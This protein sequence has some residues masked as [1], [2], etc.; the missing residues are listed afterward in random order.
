MAVAVFALG[1]AAAAEDAPFRRGVSLQA[2]TFPAVVGGGYAA[3]AYPGAD[4]TAV[5]FAV[6][7]LR[8][9]GLDHVRLPVDIGPLLR[10]DPAGRRRRALLDAV[11]PL[12]GRLHADGLGV[13]VTLVAPGLGGAIPEA[14]LDGPDGPRFLRYA[15][16]AETLAAALDDLG[17]APLALEPMN[18]PQRACRRTDGPDWAVHQPILLARLRAAAPRLWLGVTGGC[19][20]KVEGLDSVDAALLRDPRTFLSVHFYDPFLFTHQ[21]TDWALDIMPLVTG[22]SYPPRAE[23]VPEALAAARDKAGRAAWPEGVRR[24]R[25]ARAEA[26]LRHYLTTDPRPA[27]RETFADLRRRA[28]GLEI[29]AGRIVVTEFG[30]T[31]TPDRDAS[32]ARWLQEVSG[33]ISAEGWG[34]TLWVLREGPFGLDRPDGRL[35]RSLLQALGLRAP[36]GSFP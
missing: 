18:E 15:T 17:G 3:Q 25:L 4:A 7:G 24:E 36:N 19:W 23:Q 10:D 11:R 6:A 14:W 31:R 26:S 29:A 1:A 32:R 12:I 5:R 22:L 35:D 2:F 16:I 28:S 33:M 27:L 20:S 9:L 34:W 21:G 13:I 30:A 8:G